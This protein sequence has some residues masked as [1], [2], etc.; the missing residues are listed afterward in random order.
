MTSCRDSH[1]LGLAFVTPVGRCIS[2]ATA[3]CDNLDYWGKA[4]DRVRG[5]F[6]T[7][8]RFRIDWLSD[9]LIS[10]Y[11]DAIEGVC[12]RSEAAGRNDDSAVGSAGSVPRTSTRGGAGRGRH[13]TQAMVD[14]DG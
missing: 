14:V 10:A 6:R 7:L 5:F 4:N 9:H 2:I 13:S 11:I 8:L 12:Q 3:S 1:P